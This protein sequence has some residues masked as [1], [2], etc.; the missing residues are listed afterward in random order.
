MRQ[1]IQE[2]MELEQNMD[3]IISSSVICP[4]VTSKAHGPQQSEEE[5]EMWRKYA[6]GNES[7][8][9][10]TDQTHD[11]EE[12]NRLEREVA[13]F[14]LWHGA[15]FVA[16]EDPNDAELVL[17]RLEQDEIMAELLQN[18]RKQ[19]LMYR[20]FASFIFWTDAA[21]AVEALSE[22]SQGATA[23]GAWSPYESK[24]VSDCC[25]PYSNGE[26]K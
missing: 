4:E 2:E 5:K 19:L 16:E 6:L 11:A 8:S 18:S 26:S 17:D 20:V 23:A 3:F 21:D 10:G 22:G 14:D 24:T 9:A 7:F 13:D 1:S 25:F 15:D 12:R